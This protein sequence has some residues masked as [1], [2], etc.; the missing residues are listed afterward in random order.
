METMVKCRSQDP[1]RI[2]PIRLP[3]NNLQIQMRKLHRFSLGIASCTAPIVGSYDQ[4]VRGGHFENTDG[5]HCHTVHTHGRTII[6]G[7]P[8]D[9]YFVASATSGI[10]NLAGWAQADSPVRRPAC[11]A[12]SRSTSMGP[13]SPSKR[14][15]RPASSMHT[16]STPTSPCR[17]EL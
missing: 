14:L 1:S 11:A 5:T 17:L 4:V 12:A 13:V 8:A 7:H 9:A 2:L 6:P 16:F 3:V 15:G 10:S